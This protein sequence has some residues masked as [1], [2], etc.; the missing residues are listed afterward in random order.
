MNMTMYKKLVEVDMVSLDGEEFEYSELSC[1]IEDIDNTHPDDTLGY[2]GVKDY[3]LSCSID[4][5]EKLIKLGYVKHYYGER[6]SNCYKKVVPK[7][8]E[9]KHEFYKMIYGD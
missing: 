1:A 3:D 7:F 8:Y 6:Q 4:T 2:A 5:I 9:L